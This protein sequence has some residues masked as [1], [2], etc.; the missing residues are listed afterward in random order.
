MRS[1]LHQGRCF[2]SCRFFFLSIF[3]IIAALGIVTAQSTE[4][5]HDPLSYDVQVDAQIIPIYAIDK[6]GNPVF[7][8]NIED[9]E[10]T[11]DGKPQK[12]LFFMR[13]EVAEKSKD[14]TQKPQGQKTGQNENNDD[15][16]LSPDQ[17]MAQLDTIKNKPSQTPTRTKVPISPDTSTQT[18]V[19]ETAPERIN[20]I[21]LDAISNTQAGMKNGRSLV[22]KIV[23][24]GGPGDAYILFAANMN[25]GLQYISGPNKNKEKFLEKVDE[26]YN[27]P[28]WWVS[29]SRKHFSDTERVDA[30]EAAMWSVL[31]DIHYREQDDIRDNYNHSVRRYADALQNLKKAIKTIHLP[32]NIFIISGGILNIATHSSSSSEQRGGQEELKQTKT[33]LIDGYYT[34]MKNAAV[35]LNQAGAML[36][37]INPIPEVNK[38]KDASHIMSQIANAKCITGSDVNTLLE[39][40]KT[41]TAA[42]YELAFA[43]TPEMSN[44]FK[45]NIK[46][47]R[48]DVKLNTLNHGEKSQ[49]YK[50]MDKEM[51]QLF[52]LNI[53]TGGSWSRV[54]ATMQKA[55]FNLIEETPRDNSILK[56]I[57]VQIP[58]EWL[59]KKTDILILDIEPTSFKT[60]IHN[61]QRTVQHQETVEF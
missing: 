30:G 59:H 61:T 43:I 46:C 33:T 47:R 45:I 12:A 55:R 49:P 29:V 15:N 14:S 32:K 35:T 8:L 54:S 17:I 7:D 23:T 51:R 60:A 4:T 11:I 53:I 39:K 42:Y 1:N 52:A 37:M 28:Q 10:L 26:I 57:S 3:S 19:M 50:K 13:Y 56:K 27:D 41:N 25:S 22:E 38:V 36:Y 9:L 20:F 16:L 48:D 2:K 6:K 18:T 31:N 24:S 40:V 34:M 58:K 21:V 5:S 44:N